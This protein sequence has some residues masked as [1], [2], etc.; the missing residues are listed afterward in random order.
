MP[1]PPAS[2]MPDEEE[3]EVQH[4]EEV[5]NFK[6]FYIHVIDKIWTAEGKHL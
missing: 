6:V 3:P 2:K 5:S 4:M 1:P